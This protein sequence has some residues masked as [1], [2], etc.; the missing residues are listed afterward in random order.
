M[1][2]E[3]TRDELIPFLA[4]STDDDDEVLVAMAEQLGQFVPYVGGKEYAYKL[5]EPL[6]KLAH[7]EEMAV[8]D[9]VCCKYKTSFIVC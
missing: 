4:S 7:V 3:R 2:T 8:R 6:E 1:G 5:L 9:K